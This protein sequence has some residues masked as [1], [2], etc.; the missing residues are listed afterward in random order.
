M[1]A[2]GA[3]LCGAIL[4]LFLV[5]VSH[6][7]D[8]AKKFGVG[9]RL[10]YYDISDDQVKDLTLEWTQSLLYE[11]LVT[12]SFTKSLSLE[13]V[14]G[15]TETDLS[16]VEPGISSDEFGELKQFPVLLNARY[17]FWPSSEIGIYIGGGVGYYFND[18]SLTDTGKSDFPGLAVEMDDSFGFQV[19]GGVEFFL[20]DKV[21]INWDAR[22]AWNKAD[23]M[24]RSSGSPEEQ[25]EVDL[26]AFTFALG[27]KYYF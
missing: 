11:G 21:S 5:G 3:V 10:A 23:Y 20:N 16:R 27:I 14:G 9:G 4:L 18:F 15:Y 1:K 7:Q 6:A 12:Y 22:Y 24:E 13:V 25:F 2:I 17:V 19:I 8:I 26:N